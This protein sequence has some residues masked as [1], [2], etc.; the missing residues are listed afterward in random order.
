MKTVSV[1]GYKLDL[2][3]SLL[4]ELDAESLDG[5]VMAD[6]AIALNDQQR[7]LPL[8]SSFL[9]K[10]LENKQ[11]SIETARTYGRNITYCLQYLM[12][13][14]EFE[15][16]ELDDAFLT[17][18]R[19]TLK[20]YF[21]SIDALDAKTLRN[22]D[23]ALK[24]FF[25]SFLCSERASS[26]P[27]R[28]TN[29]YDEGLLTKGGKGK[30]I[31]ACDIHE[32]ESL[33]LCTNL[34]RERL[35]IQFLFDT[36][37]RRSEFE[38]ITLSDVQEASRFQKAQLYG[39]DKEN[40]VVA[41]G[42]VPLK[43]SGSKGRKQQTKPRMTLISAATL[44]RLQSYH[45]SPLYR[46]HARK[47]RS[48]EQTP[49]IFNSTGGVFGAKVVDD[50]LAKVNKCALSRRLTAK[51]ISPHK[52]RHGYAYQVLQ[53]PDFGSDYLDRLVNVQKT[54]GH[55]KLSTTEIYTRIPVDIYKTMTDQSGEILTKARKMAVLTQRTKV[56]IRVGDKK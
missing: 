41:N 11:I 35:A 36:G 6:G 40:S 19:P 4:N 3:K 18:S 28:D 49:A 7:V 31:E 56:R 23:A 33:M 38:R 53:S 55:E 48:P 20:D 22:R 34:E 10:Q 17:V 25:D 26:P 54:L 39:T 14:K 29:P 30:I 15:G 51:R 44:G 43:I 13:R 1:R 52:L 50:L 46:K 45:A 5:I 21:K 42:Y 27:F 37:V 8:V 24:A 12:R 2:S 47:Y 16:F 32:L 9:C